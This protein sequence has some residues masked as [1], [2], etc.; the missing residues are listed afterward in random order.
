MT[1]KDGLTWRNLVPLGASLA[2]LLGTTTASSQALVEAGPARVGPGHAC[3]DGLEAREA[4]DDVVVDLDELDH[5]DLAAARR[6][7]AEHYL[8]GE[9]AEA[10]ERDF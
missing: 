1:L 6:Y 3:A 7:V 10:A 5:L 4:G 9:A 8:K 2:L